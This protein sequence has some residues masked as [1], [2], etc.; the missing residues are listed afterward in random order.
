VIVEFP[1]VETADPETGLLAFGGD[2]TV[3]SL[4]LASLAGS[5]D[6]SDLHSF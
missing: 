4:E 5:C 1:P 6:L 2:L 3:G